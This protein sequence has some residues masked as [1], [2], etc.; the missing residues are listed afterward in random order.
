MPE[1]GALTE[2]LAGW[3]RNPHLERL[4]HNRVLHLAKTMLQ[5][6]AARD[7]ERRLAEQSQRLARQR[8]LLERMLLSRAFWAVERV[9][10]LRHRDPAFSREAIRRVLDDRA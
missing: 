8:Q 7:A 9:L 10:R 3:D 5:L 6:N 1:A 4:E 2:L